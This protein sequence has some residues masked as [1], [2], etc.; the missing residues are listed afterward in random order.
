MV[1]DAG[2]AAAAAPRT[3][4]AAGAAAAAAA[5]AEDDMMSQLMA[6]SEGRAWLTQG[7]LAQKTVA[8]RFERHLV[9]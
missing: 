3:Y 7:K 1:S 8:E 4:K 5:D 2:V 9:G 6:G